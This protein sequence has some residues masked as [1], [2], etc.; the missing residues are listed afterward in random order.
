MAPIT[1][2]SGD[3]LTIASG[4]SVYGEPVNVGGQ[5]NLGGELNTHPALIAGTAAGTNATGVLDSNSGRIAAATTAG[6]TATPALV[7]E[8]TIVA[9]VE[10]GTSAVGDARGEKDATAAAAAGT[11]ATPGV[12]G[13][14]DVAGAVAAGVTLSAT[15]ESI[16]P[17]WRIDDGTID[18]DRT[19]EFDAGVG[20]MD[21]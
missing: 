16:T 10:A 21:G 7:G 2:D 17:L 20:E 3:T 9:P 8:K 19:D 6:V 18:A 12:T 5:L 13:E 11:T 4:D 14:K 1:I 15:I